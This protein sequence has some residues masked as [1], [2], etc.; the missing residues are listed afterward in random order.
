MKKFWVLLVGVLVT[1]IIAGC[2][3]D[4][5]KK[6]DISGN[7]VSPGSV[8]E[9]ID[10]KETFTFAI[11]DKNC[12]ACQAYKTGALEEMESY[13]KGSIKYVEINGIDKDKVGVQDIQELIST[14]LDGQ[15]EAT[16]TTYFIKEGKLDD[17]VIG[18]VNF[19]K[20]R[21]MYEKNEGSVN[22]EE[23]IEKIVEEENNEED[24]SH[25]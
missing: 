7:Y 10:N 18:A 11:L 8:L 25:K 6:A 3:D 21:E 5:G 14:H 23:D 13:K 4:T 24:E 2:N 22:S 17:V 1:I 9:K 20:L 12:S 19:D 16:P 15:F